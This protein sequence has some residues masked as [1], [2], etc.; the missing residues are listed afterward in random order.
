MATTVTDVEAVP[1]SNLTFYCPSRDGRWKPVTVR[2][3]PCTILP[4]I[5]LEG[6]Y[7]KDRTP[8]SRGFGLIHP[9]STCPRPGLDPASTY[10]RS[11]GRKGRR[12]TELRVFS[13]S[14][15][16]RHH[17]VQ[18]WPAIPRARRYSHLHRDRQNFTSKAPRRPY[19]LLPYKRA[20][21]GSKKGSKKK[22]RR[23]T[24]HRQWKTN[25]LLY[26]HFFFE[27]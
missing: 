15:P 23:I 6:G 5:T 24:N 8:R 4:L 9:S 19:L 20:G 3:I 18:G 25:L 21:Q 16:L 12:G 1:V 26:S 22:G 17:G 27:T 10:H 11:A 13:P 2:T 7:D 14:R